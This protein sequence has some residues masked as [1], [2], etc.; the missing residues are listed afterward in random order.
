MDALASVMRIAAAGLH[1]QGTR[2]RVVAENVANANS[3]A[4]VAGGDPYRRK[5]VI[6]ANELDRAIGTE[7]VEVKRIGVDKA[8][9]GELYDPG[10]PMANAEGYV[11]TPNVQPLIEMTDMREAT[12][13]YQ[14]NLNV[15]EQ[16]RSMLSATV[17]LLRR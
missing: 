5:T 6:F 13:S 4:S 17:E 12:R 15:I 11:K 2:L 16:A 14:A 8:D 3:T 9:F 10:H 1:A 7:L